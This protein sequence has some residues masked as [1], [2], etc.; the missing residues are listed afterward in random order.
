[1]FSHPKA[2]RESSALLSGFS[3]MAGALF[4][5]FPFPSFFPSWDSYCHMLHV[6]VHRMTSVALGMCM[7][8]IHAQHLCVRVRENAY[9]TP[10]ANYKSDCSG[11]TQ[12]CSTHSS[13]ST[14]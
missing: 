1:M 3:M 2:A 11:D 14:V 8:I 9:H 13:E 5:P 6:T 12:N 10:H 7:K 4:S